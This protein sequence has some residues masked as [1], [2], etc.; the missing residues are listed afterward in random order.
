VTLTGYRA[1]E[2]GR[3]VFIEYE[4]AEQDSF[5]ARALRIVPQ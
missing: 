5:R 2:A 3:R 1:V 4:M